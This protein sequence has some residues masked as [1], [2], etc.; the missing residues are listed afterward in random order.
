[1]GRV[2]EAHCC[3]RISQHPASFASIGDR[4]LKLALGS[5]SMVVPLD[6]CSTLGILRDE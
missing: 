5:P 6:P 4:L 1:M 3:A 2:C